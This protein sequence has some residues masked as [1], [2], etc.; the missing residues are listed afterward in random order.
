MNHN[1]K[2]F[3]TGIFALFIILCILAGLTAC[4]NVE[5]D[6]NV[7]DDTSMFVC[8]ERSSVS[9]PFSIVYH[10]DTKVMYAVSAGGYNTGTFTLLVNSDGSPMLWED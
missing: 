10:K 3:L 1:L 8:C 6:I 4:S 5:N 7:Y 2:R 9:K